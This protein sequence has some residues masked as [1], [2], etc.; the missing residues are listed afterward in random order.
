[1]IIIP[2]LAL[3]ALFKLAN[4]DVTLPV[5]RATSDILV[6][7]S[8]AEYEVGLEYLSRSQLSQ[9]SRLSLPGQSPL[10][11][12]RD[13][14]FGSRV[15]LELCF[16]PL[17]TPSRKSSP[18]SRA[19]THESGSLNHHKSTTLCGTICRL[20]ASKV[21]STGSSSISSTSSPS[22]STSDF[23]SHDSFN[24]SS[25]LNSTSLPT[26]GPEWEWSPRDLIVY[27]PQPSCPVPVV[28]SDMSTL[29]T[30]H[31]CTPGSQ[32][33]YA[34]VVRVAMLKQTCIVP[35][36]D[37]CERDSEELQASLQFTRQKFIKLVIAFVRERELARLTVAN[38]YEQASQPI[39]LLFSALVYE[40]EV[41]FDAQKSSSSEDM[42]S[43]I[44]PLSQAH[45]CHPVLADDSNETGVKHDITLYTI[46]IVALA[47]V[48]ALLVC[49]LYG[50]LDSKKK[51]EDNLGSQKTAACEPLGTSVSRIPETSSVDSAPPAHSRT[52][53]IKFYKPRRLCSTL[54]P[55]ASTDPVPSILPGLTYHILEAVAEDSPTASSNSVDE[56][57]VEVQENSETAQL[58]QD[59]E[60]LENQPPREEVQE[61]DKQESLQGPLPLLAPAS[62]SPSVPGSSHT[63][64]GTSVTDL[65]VEPLNQAQD[66]PEEDV[67]TTESTHDTLADLDQN[68]SEERAEAKAHDEETQDVSDSL[69]KRKEIEPSLP[70]CPQA[71]SPLPPLSETPGQ[72]STAVAESSSAKPLDWAD[73]MSEQDVEVARLGCEDQV[74]KECD[75]KEREVRRWEKKLAEIKLKLEEERA[76][77]RRLA[78]EIIS[79]V[80]AKPV[81]GENE[82][83]WETVARRKKGK[84]SSRNSG[85]CGGSGGSGG[86]GGGSGISGGSEGGSAGEMRVWVRVE[87]EL[88]MGNWVG[89]DALVEAD[90]GEW[91]QS[92]ADKRFY[93]GGDMVNISYP[94][95]IL[96]H[97]AA[98][99]LRRD[100]AS[101]S[102]M[103]SSVPGPPAAAGPSSG[104]GW[105]RLVRSWCWKAE[106]VWSG[107]GFYHPD[108]NLHRLESD[109]L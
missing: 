84:G 58:E 43:P 93:N 101:W 62:S 3:S 82:A 15:D 52:L 63:A 69:E 109:Q 66:E 19:V 64:T 70:P 49:V 36:L 60:A 107:V 48:Y 31:R 67:A 47:V 76:E 21:P 30:L 105:R 65:P 14:Q 28:R 85:G 99:V 2:V 11:V 6:A 45:L 83:G 38:G 55:N 10:G 89:V 12:E 74:E 108:P 68:T 94:Y 102:F 92:A 9:V 71:D 98:S 20:L 80:D 7:H 100:P 37:W 78:G 86:S 46:C 77:T 104:G 32:D 33:Y 59:V 41:V 22:L 81:T 61:N 91:V 51:K 26:Y 44:L 25:T 1:M 73:S 72:D 35:R 27:V 79:S 23:H 87:L 8:G 5:S 13:V 90:E 56:G 4:P 57:E 106:E 97:P 17:P 39:A 53:A 18:T 50:V 88:D 42:E 54:P 96:F 29:P 24:A 40:N 34:D 103:A 95:P 75:E 16:A